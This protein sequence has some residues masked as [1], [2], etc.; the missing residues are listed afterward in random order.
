MRKRVLTLLTTSFLSFKSFDSV[1]ADAIDLLD[2]T[3]MYSNEMMRRMAED[4]ILRYYNNLDFGQ[5]AKPDYSTFRKAMIGFLNLKAT[6]VVEKENLITIIDFNLPS[7]K[8]RLWIIDLEQKKLLFH[9]L[10]AHGRNS[11]NL[12]AKK[13]SNQQD[14]NSSSLGFYL[15]G[16]IYYGKYGRSLKLDGMEKGFNDKLRD[17]SVVM[18]GSNYVSQKIVDRTGRLG[19]S[20]GCPAIAW[21]NKDK[22]IDTIGDNS[23]IYANGPSLKYQSTSTLLNTAEAFSLLADQGFQIAEPAPQHLASR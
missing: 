5:S 10:V 14:S 11:G 3:E 6:G 17:R 19:R 4:V 7:T 1:S 2:D 21:E 23:V 8:K 9:E 16:E 20:F 13:F 12:Y 15:T 22:I 18:H